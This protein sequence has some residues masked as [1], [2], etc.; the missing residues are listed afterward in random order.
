MTHTIL[1]VDDEASLVD[2]LA[3]V[4]EHHD[5]VVLKAYD[6]LDA[7]KVLQEN[8]IDL[9]ITDYMMPKFDGI[10]L[11]HHVMSEKTSAIPIIMMSAL[12][13]ALYKLLPYAIL[14]KPFP[15]DELIRHVEGA[16]KI[17]R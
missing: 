4:L 12:P 5:Y 1:V 2:V 9:V 17:A 11:Y 3:T 7:V 16:L 13:D 15:I 6:G 8:Q 10:A 14:K